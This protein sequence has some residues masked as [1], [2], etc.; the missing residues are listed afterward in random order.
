MKRIKTFYPLLLAFLVSS[1][2]NKKEEII[3]HDV[4]YSNKI[5]CKKNVDTEYSHVLMAMGLN[6]F[7]SSG[8]IRIILNRD[9]SNK[10]AETIFQ[11][12]GKGLKNAKKLFSLM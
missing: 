7:E 2:C 8:A 10:E 5:I 12:L 9:S 1:C 3:N 11:L 4:I 6:R